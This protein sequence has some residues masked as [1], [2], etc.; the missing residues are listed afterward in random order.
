MAPHD[1]SGQFCDHYMLLKSENASLYDLACFM[2]SSTSETSR[3]IQRTKEE[4]EDFWRRWYI[5]N[6]LFAQKLL[7]CLGKPL[8]QVGYMLELWLNLLSLNEGFLMLLSNSLKGS[9]NFFFLILVS[10]SM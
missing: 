6:S 10:N 8:V 1:Q 9:V 2:L 5:F 7:L 3:F 4:K